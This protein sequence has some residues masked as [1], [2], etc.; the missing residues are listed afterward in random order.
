MSLVKRLLSLFSI[1]LRSVFKY[2]LRA[3]QE[4]RGRHFFIASRK[5][6]WVIIESSAEM[7]WKIEK[8]TRRESKQL[9]VKMEIILWPPAEVPLDIPYRYI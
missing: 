6:K 7:Q 9:Y 4:E 2:Q 5:A 8:R 1:T 3:R